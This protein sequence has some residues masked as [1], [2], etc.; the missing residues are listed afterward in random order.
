[1]QEEE[2]M[3][4]KAEDD[5]ERRV[6]TEQRHGLKGTFSVFGW[7][8]LDVLVKY[9]I[10]LLK[11]LGFAAWPDFFFFFASAETCVQYK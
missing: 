5:E 4:Q 8:H 3:R 1:M 10:K 7:G 6:N 11:R 9:E 2:Q